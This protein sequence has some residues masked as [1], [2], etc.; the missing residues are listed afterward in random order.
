V[1]G[2]VTADEVLQHLV[3]VD[4]PADKDA[5]VAAAERHGAGDEV[6]RAIR[7]VP[8]VD[9]RNKDEVVRSLRLDPAPHRDPGLASEQAR[10]D[11]QPGIAEHLRDPQHDRVKGPERTTP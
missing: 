5:L 2:S 1:A 4:F 10:Q 3:D 6:V 9:Y 11:A 8:P 7:A